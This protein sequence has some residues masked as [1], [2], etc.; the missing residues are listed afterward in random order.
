[1]S[2]DAL[3]RQL[4]ADTRDAE[5]QCQLLA[6]APEPL[7]VTDMAG[8]IVYANPAFDSLLGYSAGE[9]RGMSTYDLLEPEDARSARLVRENAPAAGS[10]QV[11]FTGTYRRR[12]GTPRIIHWVSQIENGRIYSV[13]RDITD[14][15]NLQDEKAA[16]QETLHMRMNEF[17]ALVENNPD[18]VARFGRDHHVL[19][20]NASMADAVNLPPETMVGR[21]LRGISFGIDFELA[22]QLEQALNAVLDSGQ[23]LTF[24]FNA[25]SHD[26]VEHT[27]ETRLVP[28]FAPDGQ[29]VSVL[30]IAHDIT[31]QRE[32][33]SEL[34]ERETWYR[35]IVESQV[36]MVSR[37]TSDLTLVF[38]NEAYCRFYGGTPEDY[39][40][41]SILDLEDPKIHDTI[42]HLAQTLKDQSGPVVHE[43]KSYW[44]DGRERWIQWV[45]TG[46]QSADGVGVYQSV[47]RDVTAQRQLE[48]ELR[49]RETWYRGIVESQ[50]DLVSRHTP[51]GT[52]T[53]V[54]DAYCKYFGREREDIIGRSYLDIEPEN[55]HAE[56]RRHLATMAE[57]PGLHIEAHRTASA[58]GRERWVQWVSYSFADDNGKVTMI[59]SVGRD[60][61]DLKRTER[62]LRDSEER[63]RL[64]FESVSEGIILID[65][66]ARIRLVNRMI[67][68]RCGMQRADLANRNVGWLFAEVA[69][70]L[71][72]DAVNRA[73]TT[74]ETI[75]L[76]NE[77]VLEART[78]S[79]ELYPVELSMVPLTLSGAPMVI[80]LVRDISGRR[81]LEQQRLINRALEVELEKERELIDLKQRFTHMVTHEFRLPLT[82][83]QS[84]IDI[85]LNYADRLSQQKLA[86]RLD[87]VA[88]QA[89]RM[90]D[91]LEDALTY[92]RGEA[93]SVRLKP[94]QIDL[95]A[96]TRTVIDNLSAADNGKHSVI[97]DVSEPVFSMLTDQQMLEHIV[98]NLIGNAIKYSP[99]GS[100]VT[101]QIRRDSG[102]AVITVSDHGIGIPDSDVTRVFQP[103]HRGQNVGSRSGSGLGLPIV[104][105]SVDA[106]GGEIHL[107]TRVGQGTTFTVRIPTV[108]VTD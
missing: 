78:V 93:V 81:Q 82:V 106:L 22:V 21:A 10:Q 11:E 14:I 54:N 83:I 73:L 25:E 55:I 59:Q 61:T 53:F 70:K 36:D 103:F 105:Q 107:T 98:I 12:D 43:F 37:Y 99:A 75:T 41:R 101:V 72:L 2:L 52:L 96:F 80:C 64:I 50:I 74:N 45:S 49:E 76:A 88:K 9:T 1:M 108:A 17:R 66:L 104:K 20:V 44:P 51:D 39:I 86:E 5:T 28:E 15:R 91:L 95:T 47:G 77:D 42:R 6:K 46:V 57:R 8:V 63:F 31:R 38:V 7:A 67:E 26:G 27:Y 92:S 4:L 69:R 33:E 13:G 58:D 56:L 62:T 85:V 71:V 24:E 84:T 90:T 23:T 68:E 89:Q 94:E 102:S 18:W 60:I 32:L 35:G 16:I 87:I 29:V 65:P 97:L 48:A 30:M 34:R 19:Y 100:D 79:G 40:G 3:V